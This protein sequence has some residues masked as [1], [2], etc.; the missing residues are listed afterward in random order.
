MVTWEADQGSSGGE[1]WDRCLLASED[2]N[3]FQSFA[4][5]EYKRASGWEPQRWV[6]RDGHGRVI[7]MAQILI[8]TVL[9]GVIAGWASG[10]PVLRFPES[11][12]P[13]LT[14]VLE[15]L[16]QR[17]HSAGRVAWVRFQSQALRNEEMTSVFER[18]CARPIASL[19]SG[20]SLHIPLDRSL[21]DIVKGMTAKHRYYVKKALEE[22]IE[23]R[24]ANNACAVETLS[25]L[26]A[27]MVRRK[28]LSAVPD[29]ARDLASLCAVLKDQALIL[30]G[31]VDGEPVAA[32]LVLTFGGR[33]FYLKAATG[34]KGRELSASYAMIHRL[35][36]HLREQGVTQLDF[37]GI[38]PRSPG[39]AGVNHFKRGFGGLPVEYLGEWEW[40]SAEWLRWGANLA[41][42][43]R[44]G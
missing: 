7:A 11:G 43:S 24:I 20:H 44:R 29:H 34:Q 8:R 5:G 21:E 38:D 19:T 33:A 37:G 10:G 15:G 40:A 27:E 39:A 42:K 17:Y 22:K 9:S 28:Q 25:A 35:L 1:R 23:W 16:L 13:D 18:M 26:F 12:P 4:W 41:I 32:C 36:E 14:A 3:V 31:M 2:R 30:S 6:A